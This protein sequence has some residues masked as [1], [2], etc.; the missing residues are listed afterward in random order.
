MWLSY[1]ENEN[2]IFPF[3]NYTRRQK[4]VTQVAERVYHM[5]L[6]N[7]PHEMKHKNIKMKHSRRFLVQETLPAMLSTGWFKERITAYFTIA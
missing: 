7:N 4:G 3:S 1:N 6:Q 2:D 5:R